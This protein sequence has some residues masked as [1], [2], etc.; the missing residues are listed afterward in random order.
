MSEGKK[1][2]KLPPPAL[3]VFAVLVV[4]LA[5][6]LAAWLLRKDAAQPAADPAAAAEPGRWI[7]AVDPDKARYAPGEPV[8]FRV[9]LNRDPDQPLAGK[10]VFVAK[11]AGR[12]VDRFTVEDVRLEA[13]EGTAEAEAV[14]TPPEADYQGYL[15]ETYFVSG[16]R[17]LDHRNTAVDVS[18]DWSRFPRYGYITDFPDMTPEEIRSVIARLNR[19][20]IN[21]LQFYDWQYKHHQPLAGTAEEPAE[22][23]PDIAN[24]P[25]Y[26]DTVRGYI[27]AAHERAM[28]AMNYNLLFGTYTFAEKDGVKPEW[29]LYTDTEHRQQDGHPLPQTW[30]TGK[31]LLT[32]PANPEWQDYIFREEE[33]VFRALPFDGWHVDQL[34]DRG[35]RF[36][37]GGRPVYLDE[38]YVPFLKAA[39]DRLGV[40]LVM[41][42]VNQ[43]G[44][45]GI[46]KEAPVDFLYTEAWPPGLGSYGMLKRIVDNG[47]YLSENTKNMIIAAYMN[48]RAADRPGEFNTPSVLMTDAVIFA[49]GGAHIELGD[50]GML[51]KEYFPNKNLKMTAELEEAL[52]DYYHVMT[53]YQNWLRDTDVREIDR[54]A[55][56][57]GVELSKQD[58]PETVWFFAREKGSDEVLHLLNLATH[59]T[60]QWR[61]DFGQ[62]REPE[63]LTDL[64]VTYYTDA[65]VRDVLLVSPDRRHGS[66]ESLAFTTGESDGRRYVRF[67]LPSLKYWDMVLLTTSP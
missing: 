2:R 16:R 6:V 67:T 62:Y 20:H 61:D 15:V 34:G 19:Y 65:D 52:L 1:T 49:S 22:R 37:Y 5:A 27:D 7:A 17:T 59:S 42:A 45:V 53:A 10:L 48:Y 60:N 46:A 50:T 32:N 63:E 8:A 12:T 28:M 23:W 14:W 25:V 54:D 24:R 9:A 18:S 64:A 39:K 56:A 3:L 40:R 36:D 55:E 44:G 35:I 31:I 4:A 57:D 30:A 51:G 38:T 58:R 66:P 11:Q 29:G 21:G 26:Y 13:G 43:Y 47:R 41:N 33:N